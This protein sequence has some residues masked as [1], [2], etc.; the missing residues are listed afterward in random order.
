[1]KDLGGWKEDTVIFALKTM[2]NEWEVE[3]ACE[4]EM[5]VFFISILIVL[6]F[7]VTDTDTGPRLL[8]SAL[9][10][11]SHTYIK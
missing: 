10:S 5:V 1:M 7:T 9:L 2:E 8:D 3:V 4:E 11:L 6:R